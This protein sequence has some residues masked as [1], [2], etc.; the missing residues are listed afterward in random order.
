MYDTFAWIAKYV[1]AIVIYVFI[2][3]IVKLIY[4]DIRTITEGETA[5][6]LRP[7]LKLVTPLEGRDGELV[8]DIYPLI[9]SQTMIGRDAKCAVMLPDPFISSEHVQIERVKDRYFVEDLKSANGT[10]LNGK[11]LKDRSELRSGDRIKV[12]RAELIFSEGG[13]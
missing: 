3:R 8:A 12:G 5:T 4:A 9:G 1:M 7:H 6:A 2:F 11:P 10:V 13:R